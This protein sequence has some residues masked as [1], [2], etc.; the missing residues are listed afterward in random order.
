MNETGM[1]E[2]GMSE[3]GKQPQLHRSW[4]EVLDEEFDKPYMTQLRQFLVA[5][6]QRRAVVYPPGPFIFNALNT[7]HFDKVAVVILGQDPYHGPNQ[8][9]GLS[10]SVRRGVRLPPSLRNV[11]RELQTSLGIAPAAHGELTHW[12]E[13]GVLLLNTT[14]TVRAGQ[15]KSHAGQGWETFTDRIIDVLNVGREGL[16]FLLWGS[17]AGTKVRRI[18]RNRHLILKAVHPSPLSAHSGFFGCGHFV[19]VNEHLKGRGQAPID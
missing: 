11:Y 8:A 5:E 2:T 6:K 18:D 4:M 1:S 9:H 7:T 19:K 13:Q 10:F 16:V 12:A 14:L 3:T 17:H 15:P